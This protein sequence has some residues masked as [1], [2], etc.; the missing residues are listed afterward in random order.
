L[1]WW[2]STPEFRY[3]KTGA[4]QQQY[5]MAWAKGGLDGDFEMTLEYDNLKSDITTLSMPFS[6]S[7]YPSGDISKS[8]SVNLGTTYTLIQYGNGGSSG[9][10]YYNNDFKTSY[11]GTVLIKRT[12]S[13]FSISVTKDYLNGSTPA[14]FVQ[15]SN[16]PN[17][18][19]GKA[20]FSFMVLNSLSTQRAS[21]QWKSFSV[22]NAQ[23]TIVESFD[24]NLIL[25]K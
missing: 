4:K 25:M 6:F 16:M 1:V 18:F 20:N 11:S 19:S 15:Q 7:L 3:T 10:P 14:Q 24:S 21:I 17:W 9:L 22:K 23:G 8:T 5:T 13:D 12:G 2:T